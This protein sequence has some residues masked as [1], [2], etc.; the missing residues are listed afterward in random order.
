MQYLY[1]GV[2]RCVFRVR[3]AVSI[4]VI[5]MGAMRE[6][7]F[8][9]KW[10]RLMRWIVTV[11]VFTLKEYPHWRLIG[12]HPKL[13]GRIALLSMTVRCAQFGM[14]SLRLLCGWALTHLSVV[15]AGA[16]Q[17]RTLHSNAVGGGVVFAG[18][19]RIV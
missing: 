10:S 8:A 12:I 2:L 13:S 18:G 14:S 4:L 5:S 3:Y 9:L 16:R 19:S 6:A 11:F 15:V 17:T 7:G 1:L